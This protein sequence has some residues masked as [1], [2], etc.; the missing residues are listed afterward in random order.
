MHI[1]PYSTL[2]VAEENK[3]SNLVEQSCCSCNPP[4]R[5]DFVNS[6]SLFTKSVHENKRAWGR[7]FSQSPSIRFHIITEVIPSVSKPPSSRHLYVTRNS[8][9][10][11]WISCK[12]TFNKNFGD[13][14]SFS[15]KSSTRAV[16]EK[17][18]YEKK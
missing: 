18:S 6:I 17:T 7:P 10:I 9:F 14:H 12:L 11:Q 16:K 8:E 3:K 13:Y 5:I 15:R 1:S 4:F 2:S